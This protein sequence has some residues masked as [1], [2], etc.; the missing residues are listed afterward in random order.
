MCVRVHQVHS[1]VHLQVC[2]CEITVYVNAV[3]CLSVNKLRLQLR[4]QR[5]RATFTLALGA[6][7]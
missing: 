6:I 7:K 4:R 5:G 2:R 1:L 3:S